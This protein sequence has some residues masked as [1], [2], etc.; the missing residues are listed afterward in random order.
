MPARCEL[1]D[2]GGFDLP[3][4]PWSAAVGRTSSP[5]ARPGDALLPYDGDPVGPDELRPPQPSFGSDSRRLDPDWD[6]AADIC[7][8]VLR[9]EAGRDP[10]YKA[11]RDLVGEL[12][13]LDGEFRR[14]L[15][16]PCGM[17]HDGQRSPSLY[18]NPSRPVVTSGLELR[19][20]GLRMGLVLGLRL[21][22][23]S[24]GE[25][26]RWRTVDDVGWRL[27]WPGDESFVIIL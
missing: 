2:A 21:V 4:S 11:M 1:P 7:V 13:T 16:A 9:T 18:G 26:Q 24:G 3:A 5:P 25:Q 10:H 14:H 8:A 27:V 23:G 15:S 12:S 20:L 22:L 6:T 19:D 17:E